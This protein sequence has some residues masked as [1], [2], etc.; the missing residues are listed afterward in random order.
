MGLA[1][2]IIERDLPYRVWQAPFAEAKFSPILA[3]NDL[4]RVRRVLDVG[5]G[6]GTN[7][8]HFTRTE[9]LGLDSNRAYID[10]ARRR[11]RRNF[12][13]ADVTRYRVDDSA[14]FDFILIN[15]FLHHID[16]PNTFRILAHLNS[17][18]TENGHV[19]ILELVLPAQ[20]SAARFLARMDRGN[21]PRPLH[22][23]HR[24]FSHHFQPVL[25][26]PY[27]LKAFGTV[28]WNMVY[29]KGRKKI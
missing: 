14:R 10:S 5:C 6:P 19:H 18:L 11:H 7:T 8:H 27:P 16:T 22:M 26:E 2:R 17:L 23:W 21:F 3:H 24:I 1:D 25:F 20:R 28:L 4:A 12:V 13:V 9:Y 29:F 15:S